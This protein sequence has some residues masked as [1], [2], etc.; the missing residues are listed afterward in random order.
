MNLTPNF[1][2][3]EM[4]Y[5]QTALR[6]GLNNQPSKAMIEKLRQTAQK[7]EAVRTLLGVPIHINSAYR[8]PSVNRAIGGASTSQHCKGE[9]VDFVAPQFG[10]P[11][12]ICAA[13]M[14][15]NIE[16]DQLIFEGSWVHISFTDNPRNSKLT[17]VFKNGSVS[18][19]GGIAA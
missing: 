12:D 16:F 5:S 13:I 19:L 9:A 8:S 17:A 4:T 14:R 2:L 6:R 15:S 3:E 18:Y 11:K 7:M 1:T 10:T